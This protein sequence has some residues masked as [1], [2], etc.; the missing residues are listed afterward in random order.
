MKSLFGLLAL[1]A[2]SAALV[3]QLAFANGPTPPSP[4]A[5]ISSGL[6]SGDIVFQDSEP[7]SG[8]APAIKKLTKSKW[9]H[10]GIYFDRPGGPVVVEAVGVDH[11]Y[12]SWTDWRDSAADKKVEARRL[13]TG[14]TA[15]QVDKLWTCALTYAGKHYDLKFEWGPERIYCSELVWLAFHDAGLGDVGQL[16]HLGDFD[17]D[18]KEGR[19]LI[20]RDGSWGTVEEAHLH[21]EMNV[22]SPQAVLESDLLEP[23]AVP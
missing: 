23:V 22:I 17:L 20:E 1:I 10:C 16:G 12:K 7:H 19:K 3:A 13:K 11:Q 6:K 18:S 14:V 21:D 5:A 8:Q 4:S 9:S 2:L 15:E